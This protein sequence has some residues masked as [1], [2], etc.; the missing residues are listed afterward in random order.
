MFQFPTFA[1]L[2][3]CIQSRM[4]RS[5]VSG[6]PI[7]ISSDQSLLPA[8]RGFS[9]AATSFFASYCQGIHPVRLISWPYNPKSFQT[10]CLFLIVITCVTSFR[11]NSLTPSLFSVILVIHL[12][13][14][15]KLNLSNTFSVLRFSF[16]QI[17]KE[18][19]DPLRV[20]NIIF[21][22]LPAYHSD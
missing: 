6:F 16:Y 2:D 13:L 8:P 3:L 5:L 18:L 17:V 9:Q 11:R 12:T 20:Q 19:S 1:S 22:L 21:F 14:N 15:T 10:Q 4:I 7:Q